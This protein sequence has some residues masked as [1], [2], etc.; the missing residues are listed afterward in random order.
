MEH[1][2]SMR[3]PMQGN[4]VL[5]IPPWRKVRTSLRDISV[6]GVSVFADRLELPVNTIVTLAISL[7][8]DGQVSHHR[9]RGQVVHCNARRTGLVFVNPADET[10]QVLRR[11]SDVHSVDGGAAVFVAD[12]SPRR[13]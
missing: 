13:A 7:I 6:G 2:W 3:K 11:L 5:S 4:V 9:L 10:L 12:Q 8:G 1:R